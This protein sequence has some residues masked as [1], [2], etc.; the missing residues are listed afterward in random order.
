MFDEHLGL[1]KIQLSFG[2]R[3]L[4]YSVSEDMTDTH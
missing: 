3:M 4:S 2:K 1:R